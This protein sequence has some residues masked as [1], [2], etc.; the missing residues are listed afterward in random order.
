MFAPVKSRRKYAF[1]KKAVLPVNEKGQK[2]TGILMVLP[3]F[4]VIAL[5]VVYPIAQAVITSFQDS[6][7]MAFSLANYISIFSDKARLNDIL[8]T[9]YIV[10]ITAVISVVIAYLLS[11][12]IS[13]GTSRLARALERNYIIPQFVPGIVAIYA[14]INIISN[15]GAIN[16]FMMLFGVDFKPEIVYTASSIILMNLWFNIP[17]SAMIIVSTISGIPKS[18][19]ESARDVGAGYIQIFWKMILPLSY[20]SAL[21]AGVFVF[22]GCIGQYTVPSLLG[23]NNPRMLGVVLYQQ[24]NRFYNMEYSSA[25]S[26]IIFLLSSAAGIVYIRS[27]MKKEK[28]QA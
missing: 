24:F 5:F 8:Y 12:Y 11:L 26:V 22:M 9:L 13:F 1:I 2:L 6:E 19:I 28:W 15:S 4:I 16:R 3:S 14:I 27:M 17:F 18:I 25:L 20:K 23:S 21:V 10:L 7:S